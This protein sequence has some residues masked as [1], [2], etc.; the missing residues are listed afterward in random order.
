MRPG[1]QE[2]DQQ[3][4][5]GGGMIAAMWLLLI[6]LMV[7]LFS[8]I[9]EKQTNPNQQ[10]NSVTTARGVAEVTLLR[11]KFGHYITNGF[12]NGLPVTFMLDTGAS[13]VSIPESV[14]RRLQLRKGYPNQYS[15]A[16]GV[17]TAWTTKLDDVAIGDIHLHQ[18]RASI[19][20]AMDDDKILLGMSFL[21]QI[22]FTQRGDELILRQYPQQSAREEVNPDAVL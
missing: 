8:G 16:N 20:P 12:I 18:V 7:F 11:N 21:K 13:D 2:Q 5:L 15:T 3:K 9:L 10:V 19:N 22:E 17:I 14:A 1:T 6:A 4:R